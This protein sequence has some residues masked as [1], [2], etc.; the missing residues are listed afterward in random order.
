MKRQGYC[1]MQVLEVIII[2]L[3][4]AAMLYAMK[5]DLKYQADFGRILKTHSEC[6]TSE[7]MSSIR[8]CVKTYKRLEKLK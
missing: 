5:V 8:A 6:A 3:A 7:S 1:I 2:L 4:F